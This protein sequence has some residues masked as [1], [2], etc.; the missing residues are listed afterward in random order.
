MCCVRYLIFLPNRG[1]AVVK[2]HFYTGHESPGV[3]HIAML[4]HPLTRA[5]T[6]HSSHSA[7]SLRRN[8][9]GIFFGAPWR[10]SEMLAFPVA[11]SL[12]HSSYLGLYF[13][14]LPL[15][16]PSRRQTTFLILIGVTYKYLDILAKER[17]V[18]ASPPKSWAW[19]KLSSLSELSF[20]PGQ[21][22]SFIFFIFVCFLSVK[23]Y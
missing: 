12:C 7:E 19:R 15:S 18:R 22:A 6:Q 20:W 2:E 21:G 10:A 1:P 8:K 13:D 3:L 5:V 14:F 16:Q 9:R 17:G 4:H 23:H 11:Y